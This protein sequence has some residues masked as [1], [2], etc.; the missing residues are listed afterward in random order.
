MLRVVNPNLRLFDAK[1]HF[2]LFSSLRPA[3]FVKSKWTTIWPLPTRVKTRNSESNT[4]FIVKKIRIPTLPT[5][6]MTTTTISSH[7]VL[8]WL[9][10]LQ[11]RPAIYFKTLTSTSGLCIDPAR[12]ATTRSS[13][14]TMSAQKTFVSLKVASPRLKNSQNGTL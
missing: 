1:L 9:P 2:A 11:P 6:T 14:S 12:S 5:L 10:T 7:E 4:Y 3:I 8:E 13:L